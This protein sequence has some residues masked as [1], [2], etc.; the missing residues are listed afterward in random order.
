MDIE[1]IDFWDKEKTKDN[2]VILVEDKTCWY[3]IEQLRAW[4][5]FDYSINY[6][7]KSK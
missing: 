5:N 1:R 7:N 6:R 3:N 2:I 4:K